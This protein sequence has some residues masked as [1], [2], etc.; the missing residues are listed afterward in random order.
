[1]QIDNENGYKAACKTD[2]RPCF[3]IAMQY[4]AILHLQ[5]KIRR[6]TGVGIAHRAI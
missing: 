2:I 5:K 1:M 3:S 6:I 4:A